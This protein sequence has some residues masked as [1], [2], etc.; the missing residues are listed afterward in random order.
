[1]SRANKKVFLNTSESQQ[2]LPRID[3]SPFL[4][5]SFFVKSFLDVS[6]VRS[7]LLC[8]REHSVLPS[9]P[10][11]LQACNWLLELSID[12]SQRQDRSTI[13]SAGNLNSFIFSVSLDLPFLLRYRRINYSYADEAG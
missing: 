8:P 10:L 7:H 1:M 5:N 3:A 2:S 9:K 4:S 11:R 13:P 6:E 12:V